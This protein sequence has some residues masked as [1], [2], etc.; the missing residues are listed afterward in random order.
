MFHYISTNKSIQ[1]KIKKD[2]KP[3]FSRPKSRNL[4]L[5]ISKGITIILVVFGH[6]I[7]Y[8]SFAYKNDIFFDNPIFIAIY[9]FHMPLFMLICG[10]LFYHSINKHSWKYNFKSRFTKL[11]L[12]IIIWNSIYIF[13][14]D[15]HR[16]WNSSDI[17][18][19]SQLVSYLSAIWFLWAIFWCSLVLLII[20]RYFKD[21]V[22]VYIFVGLFALVLPGISMY[23]YMYPYFIMGYLFNKYKL[24]NKI[25]TFNN[26]TKNILSAFLFIVFIGLY[27][28]YTKEDYIYTTGT[29]IVKHIRYL[30][31]KI[32]LHQISID[33][34]R[35]TIGLVG[36]I[37]AL[38]VIRIIYKHIGGKTAIVLGKIGQKSIGIY[39]ISTM[40]INNFILSRLPHREN[41][42]YGMVIIETIIIISITYFLTYMLEK[43]K[44]TRYLMLGSRK[45]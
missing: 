37:C 23:V 44:A 30:N 21:S 36:S 26:N 13:I 33:I 39:I 41:F 12:P 7:Q 27:F 1:S 31:P 28:L 45:I 11:V 16:L 17:P 25:T 3:H 24:S 19:N 42:G 43:N 8:G 32:D 15:V 20:H 6:N 4:Y 29:T 22:I 5:D 10:Y 18:W 40:F 9:S 2:S 14:I 34:F 35:Y 38:I